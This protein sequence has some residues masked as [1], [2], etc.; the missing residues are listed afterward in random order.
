[1]FAE[2]LKALRK[3]LGI[4]QAQ[5]AEDF[6]I[7]QATIAMWETGRREPDFETVVQIAVYFH[8][9]T[10]FLLGNEQKEKPTPEDGGGLDAKH[11]ELVDLYDAASPALRAAALAVLRSADGQVMEAEPGQAASQPEMLDTVEL[12]INHYKELISRQLKESSK[13]HGTLQFIERPEQF[14]Y[15]KVTARPKPQKGQ[16]VFAYNERPKTRRK[17]RLRILA[18]LLET[19]Q[20]TKGPGSGHGHE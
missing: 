5:F 16:Y 8:V 15:G 1:M 10:D 11:Q 13:K 20:S 18:K 12:E 14:E 6:N 7:A 2:R 19:A 3:G 17:E 9:S 4:T